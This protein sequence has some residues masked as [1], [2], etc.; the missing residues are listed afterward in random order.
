MRPD[1]SDRSG[2][3]GPFDRREVYIAVF[4]DAIDDPEQAGRLERSPLD[5]RQVR[6]SLKRACDTFFMAQLLRYAQALPEELFCTA[7]VALGQGHPSQI[8]HRID[9]IALVRQ[10]LEER[11][12]L[13]IERLGMRVV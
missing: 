13:C 10:F 6:E 2:L 8:R 5:R 9:N 4:K 3:A 12:A 7:V 11:Q 1:S